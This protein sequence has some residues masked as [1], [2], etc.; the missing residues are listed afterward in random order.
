MFSKLLLKD[1]QPKSKIC[2]IVITN[3][4]NKTIAYIELL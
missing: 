3:T 2:I 1:K 4:I